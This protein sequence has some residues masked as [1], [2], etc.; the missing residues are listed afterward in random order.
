MAGERPEGWQ[1]STLAVVA[2]ETTAWLFGPVFGWFMRGPRVSGIEHLADLR[3]AVLICPTHA[4][5][6]DSSAL[7]LALG[8]DHRRRLAPAVAA[9][10]FT[11][12]PVRWFFAAWLGAFPFNRRGRGG[13]ESFAAAEALLESGWSVLIYPEGTRSRS[14]AIGPFR[15]GIGL[16]ATRTGRQVLPVRIIGTGGVLP[17]GAHWP[18]RASV[19]VHFGAPL[20]AEVDEDARAFTAR[21]EAVVRSL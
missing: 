21:L 17:P 2:R 3:E 15:P 13:A 5:H 16:L 11:V 19:E 9:D 8:R 4:S 10:Y 20:R 18:H 6:L 7:R 12:S 1:F 14:D